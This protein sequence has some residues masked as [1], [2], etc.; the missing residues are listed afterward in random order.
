MLTYIT[1]DLLLFFS[2]QRQGYL[3]GKSSD[4]NDVIF[5]V[6]SPSVIVRQQTFIKFLFATLPTTSAALSTLTL[7]SLKLVR[8]LLTIVFSHSKLLGRSEW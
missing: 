8:I 6:V 1:P 2:G 7:I 5:S 3:I 4:Q